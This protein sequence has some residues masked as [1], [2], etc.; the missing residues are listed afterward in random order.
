M[1]SSRLG[2]HYQPTL[3]TPGLFASILCFIATA[4]LQRVSI[5]HKQPLDVYNTSTEASV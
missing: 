2:G 5:T 1:L 4:M 3:L